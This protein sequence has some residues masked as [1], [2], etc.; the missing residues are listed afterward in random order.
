[1]PEEHDTNT[2]KTQIYQHISQSREWTMAAKKKKIA[3]KPTSTT[4]KK[5]KTTKPPVKKGEKVT[6]PKKSS[7]PLKVIRTIREMRKYLGQVRGR[8]QRVALVPTMGFLHE[9]HLSLV[10]EARK[11]AAIV[12][13]S[14]FVNPAQFAP[15][16][17]LD[18]Y[19]RDF[20]GDR[21]KLKHEGATVI[22][23][24]DP[25]EIYPESFQ[26]FVD[27]TGVT[28]DF[29]GASRPSHFRGVTTVVNLLINIIKPDMA[30]F[31]EKDFQQ[32]VTIRRMVKDFRL[33]I[34]IMGMPTLREED[35][36][37]MSSRN[38]FLSPAQRQ[39]AT[40]IYRGLRKAR[41]LLDS[42]ERDAAE[43]AAVVLDLLREEQNLE[44]E[45]V[46]VCDP[47]TLE[48]IPEVEK[49]SVLLVAVRV[50]DTRLIDNMRLHVRPVRKR[51][52][53]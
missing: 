28:R 39:Q 43:L 50:G 5:T 35:G 12:V 45:Y 25:A 31:G 52:R 13:V 29:C 17:D 6:S 1:M 16:E 46:A 36:L 19:P 32:L 11:H 30:I 41:R 8:N 51:K 18:R 42:G 27:V 4:A 34:D 9:G 26:T 7:P 23:A 10:R 47:E 22:F 20:S 14:I 24:P 2:L 38:A 33:E 49:K 48:R 21:R 53:K 3:K 37:A 40:A 15:T 44:I